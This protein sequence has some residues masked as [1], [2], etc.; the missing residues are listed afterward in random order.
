MSEKTSLPMREHKV[1]EDNPFKERLYEQIATTKKSRVDKIWTKSGT[2]I[3]NESGE[4]RE[5]QDL[6]VATKKVVDSE[7]FTKVFHDQ[8]KNTAD[9]SDR[10]VRILM[11]YIARELGK[12]KL[13]VIF[14][15]DEC[16]RVTAYSRA[17]IYRALGELLDANIIA[18]TKYQWMFYINPLFIFN[19]DRISVVTQYIKDVKNS[20]PQKLDPHDPSLGP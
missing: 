1:Y 4:V 6:F 5:G 19:G 7:Q 14:D 11:W 20:G 9:I 12:D 13:E 3:D 17:S 16:E 18:R 2:V 15:I 10:A 8:I